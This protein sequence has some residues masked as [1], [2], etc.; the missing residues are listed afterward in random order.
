M[1][2]IIGCTAIIFSSWG[3]GYILGTQF[4]CRVRE[5]K[6]LK[7]SFQM[8]ETEIAYSNAPLPDALESVERR[9]SIPVK[10][11]FINISKNLKTRIYSSV[12]EAFEKSLDNT[13]D[14][15]SLGKEDIEILKSFGH[16]LGNSDVEGQV[17][18][19]KLLLKQLEIQESKAEDARAKNERMY[20]SLG[21]LS[22]L[23]IVILLL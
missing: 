21:F 22:G 10:Y 6:L 5:L 1:I 19:F 11:F 12:G 20:K 13:K 18:N 17:K 9:S 3:L 16:S 14:K 7:S 2:K 8:L 15:L 4:S 23:A